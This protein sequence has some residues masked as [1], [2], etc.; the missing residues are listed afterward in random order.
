MLRISISRKTET[1]FKKCIPILPF[2]PLTMHATWL[3][4]QTHEILGANEGDFLIIDGSAA[5]PRVE[6]AAER[7]A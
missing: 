1:L 2:G 3:G 4:G 6:V 7:A 5:E